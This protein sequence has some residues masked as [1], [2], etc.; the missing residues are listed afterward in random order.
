MGLTNEE[1]DHLA[2]VEE[3]IRER[4]SKEYNM[5]DEEFYYE[6]ENEEE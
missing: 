4:D 1:V 3:S 5:Y 2:L 6:R